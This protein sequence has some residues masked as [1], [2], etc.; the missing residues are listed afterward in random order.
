MIQ[1]Q[2]YKEKVLEAVKGTRERG[3]DVS[4]LGCTIL[5]ACPKEDVQ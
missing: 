2:K 5:T 3:G 1:S 4:A